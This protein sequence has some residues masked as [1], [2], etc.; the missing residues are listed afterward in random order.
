MKL[1]EQEIANGRL[2]EESLRYAVQQ[3]NLQGYVILEGVLP[4]DLVAELR[5]SFDKVFAAYLHQLDDSK[6]GEN[7]PKGRNRYLTHLP[8]RLPFID[9]RVITNP[10]ALSVIDAI[11]GDNSICGYL[12]AD[13][14]LPDSDYQNVHRDC[15]PLFPGHPT[16]VPAYALVL[17]I[18]L[19]DFRQDNGPLEYWP[20]T[21]L[22]PE[23]VGKL[24][25]AAQGIAS[26]PAIMPAGSLFIRDVR[27]WH[28]GTPNRSVEMRPNMALIYR[29]PWN[30]R[31]SEPRL[32]IPQETFAGLSDRAKKLFRQE[33]IGGPL[34]TY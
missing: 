19:V 2:S 5:S 30:Y 11:L 20:G 22:I 7:S 16:V 3:V 28:R 8:F 27:M 18:N 1:M 34:V 23:N 4:R 13:T 14:P 25:E 33:N 6:K 26:V 24:N 29:R 21:H 17:N 15:P 31:E 10:L 12:A 9:P 32:G